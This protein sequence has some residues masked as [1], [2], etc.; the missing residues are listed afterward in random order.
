MAIATKKYFL[1]NNIL[2]YSGSILMPDLMPCSLRAIGS[3]TLPTVNARD[4]YETL[5]ITRPGFP[6]WI[7]L[8][9]KSAHLQANYDYV[10]S[11]RAVPGFTKGGA[12]VHDYYLT[13]P[14]AAQ[15]AEVSKAANALEVHHWLI[16]QAKASPDHLH[17]TTETQTPD[18]TPRR[19]HMDATNSQPYSWFDPET[20]SVPIPHR[21]VNG[22]VKLTR[23]SGAQT[24]VKVATV[25]LFGHL[26]A[27]ILYPPRPTGYPAYDDMF[28]GGRAECIPEADALAW[29][30]QHGLPL[31]DTSDGATSVSTQAED[32]GE[33]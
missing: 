6:A 5:G 17:T 22:W 24:V 16:A 2:I 30:K 26:T 27:D 14:A 15:I 10:V 1:N 21:A 7:K 32:G 19:S 3:L 23:W 13:C 11:P 33:L 12:S 31:P 25:R 4:L 18:E 20:D 9:V 29:L 28:L 8:Q